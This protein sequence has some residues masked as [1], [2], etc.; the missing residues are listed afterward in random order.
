MEGSANVDS[1]CLTPVAFFSRFAAFLT[2]CVPKTKM[3]QHGCRSALLYQ[4]Y[5]DQHYSKDSVRLKREFKD[6]P[7]KKALI[8]FVS[9]KAIP[10]RKVGRECGEQRNTQH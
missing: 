5:P 2:V 10:K 7:I 6:R 1:K 3:R 4:D 8:G 9:A